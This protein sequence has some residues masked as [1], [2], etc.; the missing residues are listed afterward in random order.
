LLAEDFYLAGNITVLSL[1][2]DH[3]PLQFTRPALAN[4]VEAKRSVTHYIVR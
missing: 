1:S 4:V 3:R 2:K